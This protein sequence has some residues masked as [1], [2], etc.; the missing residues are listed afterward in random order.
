MAFLR[1]HKNDILLIA[2]I[3]VISGAVWGYTHFTR[4]TGAFVTVTVDG[5]ETARLPLSENTSLVIGQGEHTNTLVIEN[6]KAHIS[7][8]SCPDHVCI[9]QGEISCDGQTIVCLPNKLVVEV[10][11]GEQG[12]LDAVS[13]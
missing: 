8:A 1:K 10:T 7:Q 2:A 5:E 11:G 12:A 13:Q 9:R 6:G 4:Q 3:L